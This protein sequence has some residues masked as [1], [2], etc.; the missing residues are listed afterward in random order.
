MT[1]K[2]PPAF[3][4]MRIA[5][6]GGSF[7]P[8]HEGHRH[9]SLEALKRLRLDVVWWVVSP[10]NPLKTRAGMADFETRLAQAAAVAS[11][12]R[13]IVADFERAV[14]AGYTIDTVRFL[15]RRYPG[16]SFV[17]IMG[18]DGLA[19][20][21]CWRAWRDIMHAVPMAVFD[22]PG[23]RYRALAAAAATAFS[24]ARLAESRAGLLAGAT[25]PAWSFLSIPLSAASSTAL[26]LGVENAEP[27]LALEKRAEV[28]QV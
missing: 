17:W 16:T 13:V 7:N 20:F 6:M 19:S 26:R 22:R 21:H 4:G 18:A 3:P 12:P 8:A 14:G 15:L 2:P 23:W 28:R 24:R 5:L 11:H 25:P 1:A 10:Q 9:I 27:G